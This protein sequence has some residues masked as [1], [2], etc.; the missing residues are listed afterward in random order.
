MKIEDCYY[1]GKV[2]KPFGYKGEVV[3]FLDV[4]DMSKYQKMDSVFIAMDNQ[5]IPFFIETMHFKNNKAI[6][7][8]TDVSIEESQRLI[9]KELYLP[10]SKLPKLSGK[11]FYFHEVK[12]FQMVD[13]TKGAI[14]VVENILD[15]PGQDLFQVNLNGKEILIPAIDEVIESIDRNSKTI[16]VKAPEGL[17]DLYLED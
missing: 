4:D 5:L 6:V 17:I 9:G 15:Y 14:G 1:L 12:G 11:K 7:R 8:F 13:K 2:T 3:L 10:L 16:H